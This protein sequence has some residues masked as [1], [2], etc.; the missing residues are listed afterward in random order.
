[1]PSKK[2]TQPEPT[3]DTP[4]APP[5]EPTVEPPKNPPAK[6]Q[7]KKKVLE[8]EVSA[9]TPS[10]VS[11][12]ASATVKKPRRKKNTDKKS[13]RTPSSY[14][15]F[16][17]DERKTIVAKNPDLNLG[18][19][20]K[21]CG[22]AWKALSVEDREPW[23]KK[24]DELKQTRLAEIA[25]ENKNNPPKKKRAPSSYL[26]FAMEHRKV[27]LQEDPSLVIGDVSKKCGQVWKSMTDSDKQ[28]WKD[29]AAELKN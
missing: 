19:V 9:V 15:L 10:V 14:V 3:G 5:A 2:R 23:Q 13:S 27:V 20:S 11:S 16:S 29:K 1:M 26:L 28:V 17:M 4:P 7:R 25:E 22:V 18:G 24:A 12:T 21:Q 6:R 8:S